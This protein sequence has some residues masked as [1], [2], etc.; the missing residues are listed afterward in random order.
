MVR[1]VL[2]LMKEYYI[3][4]LLNENILR[5]LKN[6]HLYPQNTEAPSSHQRKTFANKRVKTGTTQCFEPNETFVSPPSQV[7][8]TSLKKE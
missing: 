4:I 7:Q 2:R 1:E 3:D 8:G 5:H 6:I